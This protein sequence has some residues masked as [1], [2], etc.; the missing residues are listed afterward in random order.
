MKKILVEVPALG[1]Y[2]EGMV[3][4]AFRPSSSFDT[5]IVA[6]EFAHAI[7]RNAHLNGLVS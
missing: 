6:A 7:H 2:S 4:L 5:S 1:A 3:P